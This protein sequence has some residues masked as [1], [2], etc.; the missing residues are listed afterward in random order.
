[1]EDAIFLIWA[2]LAAA[3]IPQA[4]LANAAEVPAT[5]GARISK[6]YYSAAFQWQGQAKKLVIG[7]ASGNAD[8]SVPVAQIGSAR[9]C[10][11]VCSPAAL[12]RDEASRPVSMDMVCRSVAFD[13]AS[14]PATLL[15][16]GDTGRTPTLR[17]GSWL[18]GYRQ[19]S[20][21]VERDAYSAAGA[22][23]ALAAR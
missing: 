22:R 21:R 4:T 10:E 23:R 8:A 19:A 1:M 14:T 13:A 6:V 9:G 7:V 2:A 18:T 15:W 17:F 12:E 3:L 11:A 5:C 16:G 20:L